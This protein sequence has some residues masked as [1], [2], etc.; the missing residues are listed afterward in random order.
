M[1]CVPYISSAYKIKLGLLSAL[2]LGK[3][4]LTLA[5][6]HTSATRFVVRSER[7]DLLSLLNEST[8]CRSAW[9]AISETT[10]R[11]RLEKAPREP[12]EAAEV[13]SLA[14]RGWLQLDESTP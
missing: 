4:E 8:V 11:G 9:L 12:L 2:S 5:C 10:S 13:S 14:R 6:S 3:P 1:Q 7:T